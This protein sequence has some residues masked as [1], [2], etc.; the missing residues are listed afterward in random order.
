[1]NQKNAARQ[2]SHKMAFE[3][4]SK[5]D[6]DRSEV[7]LPLMKQLLK[8]L[9]HY[10]DITHIDDVHIVALPDLYSLYLAYFL[11]LLGAYW[12]GGDK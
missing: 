4:L 9:Q 6:G 11:G 10:K 12:V 8:E 7:G 1:M 3:E 2:D 5:I